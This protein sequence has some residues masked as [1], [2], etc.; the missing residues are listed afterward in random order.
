MLSEAET[1]PASESPGDCAYTF[2]IYAELA[3]EVSKDSDCETFSKITP[4]IFLFH[5]KNKS[6]CL[7]PAEYFRGSS[8]VP[9]N[10]HAA[11]QVA[12]SLPSL[13]MGK[14]FYKA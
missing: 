10:P 2:R 13:A 9:A 1:Y 11:I 4:P 7:L 6:L 5:R 14:I 12:Y 3:V 8:S